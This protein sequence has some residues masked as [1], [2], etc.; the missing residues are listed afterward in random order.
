MANQ[1]P[2]PPS[3]IGTR[4]FFMN[5]W[6][7]LRRVYPDNFSD[8]DWLVFLLLRFKL[9]DCKVPILPILQTPEFSL[10]FI[11]IKSNYNINLVFI[12]TISE[13]KISAG[14][15]IFYNLKNILQNRPLANFFFG[16]GLRPWTPHVLDWGP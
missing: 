16:G 8:F 2:P 11:S 13:K 9:S 14:I 7:M 5:R 3:K 12:N 1:T 10:V 6:G 4:D 15:K